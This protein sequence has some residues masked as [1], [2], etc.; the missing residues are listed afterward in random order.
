MY[1]LKE[2][3]FDESSMEIKTH[4]LTNEQHL[5]DNRKAMARKNIDAA[6]KAVNTNEGNLAGFDA[7][8]ELVDS[9]IKNGDVVQ[10][11]YRKIE[12]YQPEKLQPDEH[13]CVTV[14]IPAGVDVSGKADKVSYAT[15]GNFAG[16]DSTGNLTNSGKKATDF[17]TAAQGE[18][19]DTAYQKPSAGIPKSDLSSDVQTSLGLA[20]T[21]LQEHQDISGKANKSEM[22]ITD[23]DGDATKKNIQLKEGLNQD[24]V[25]AHQDVSDKA[26]KSEMAITDVT[27]ESTKKNIQ[28]KDGLDQ[29]VVVEH[30]D[31]SGKAEKSEMAI[32]DV[33][34]DSTKKNIQLKDGLAQ[35]VVVAHQDVSS[36]AEKSEMSITAVTGDDTKKNIQLK[37]GL[38]QNVVIEHQDISGKAEKSEM[39]IT[40]V[41]SDTTKK[42]IQLKDGL[43]QDV[44]VA[45]QDISGKAEKSEMSI[46]D[47]SGDTTKKNIQLKDGLSQAVVVA[48]QDISGKEDTSNKVTSWSQPTTDVNYPS[49]KLVKDSLDGKVDK[50]AGK[51]LVIEPDPHTP[52]TILGYRGDG[53][54]NPD[55]DWRVIAKSTFGESP[56]VLDEQTGEPIVDENA[57]DLWATYDGTGFGAE[58]AVA[59]R[60]GQVIDETYATKTDVAN[61]ADKVSGAVSGHFAS[62]TV[63]GN[64]DDSGYNATNFVQS[65]VDSQTNGNIVVDGTE[66]N[67]Y[68]HPEPD[69]HYPQYSKKL[70]KVSVD[71]TGH[72][73]TDA[74]SSL[75]PTEA[76]DEDIANTGIFDSTYAYNTATNKGATVAHVTNAVSTAINA[77]DNTASSDAGNN[78]QVTVTQE[79][80]VVTAVS[81]RDNS[82]N[83]NDVVGKADKVSGATAGNFAGLNA[84]GNLTDSGSKASDFATAAQGNKADTAIQGVQKN[85]ADLT[86]DANKKVNVV[87]NNATLTV[88]V[89]SSSPVE[90]SADASQNKSVT[91][92]LASFDKTTEPKQYGEG[93]MTGQ[94]KEKLNDIETG[95][96]ANV[97]EKVQ[98]N[99]TDL[100]IT[101]KTVN[102][103]VNDGKLKT[104][105]GSATSATDLFSADASTEATLEIP[106]ASVD[107]TG[108]T[109][110]YSEGLMSASDKEK[111]EGIEA[112]AEEN[113]VETISIGGGTPIAPTTNT[114]NIDIPLADFDD[115]GA[116]TTYTD[117]AMSGEDKEKLN[118]LKNF[119]KVTISDGAATPTTVDCEPSSATD[120][121]TIVAGNNIT[122]TKAQNANTVTIDAEGGTT[123]S[124]GRGVS[125]IETPTATGT[126]YEVSVDGAV[127][128]YGSMTTINNIT[129]SPTD[130]LD[131]SATPN[132]NSGNDRFIVALNQTDN[133]VYLYALKTVKDA[134]DPTNDVAG[135]DVFTL[136]FNVQVHR[137]QAHGF[138]GMAGVQ[139]VRDSSA[140]IVL[141]SSTESYPSNVGECSVN[142]STTVWNNAGT[143]TTIT[144]PVTHESKDYYGYRLIY[145]GDTSLGVSDTIQVDA[146]FSVVENMSGTAEYTG[147][148]TQYTGGSA[149]EI[150]ANTHEV[151]V[152]PGDG[153]VIDTSTNTLTVNVKADGGIK[154]YSDGL[155]VS[156]GLDEVTE[157]VVDTVQEISSDMASKLTTNF[158]YPMIT[159]V[160]YDFG[161]LN[162]GGSCICQLFSVPFRHPIVVDETY[163]MIYIKDRGYSQ[164]NVMFGI[165]QYDPAGNNNTGKTDF[166]CD[167]G[168]V[169]IAKPTSEKD[170]LEFPIKHVN[171]DANFRALRPDCMYYAVLAMPPNAGSG[172]FLASA[173]NY[174]DTVNSMPTLNWRITNCSL[175]NWNDPTNATLDETQVH[176]WESGYNEHESMN[177]FFMQIRNHVPQNNNNNGN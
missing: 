16:L 146:R 80:G 85:G 30:Q 24:V 138:Y 57:T 6:K 78:V 28:L 119:S 161:S 128:Y 1:K 168:A 110:V 4:V 88:T 105:I 55:P 160:S 49:E 149:I 17:A 58:R 118:K 51:G 63:S 36:K 41:S 8:G 151:S 40:D 72:V 42:T 27:G 154:L 114:T 31:I 65:V 33:S 169:S 82:I 46:T 69:P 19:A 13:G 171:S 48:H 67:V 25:V 162:I 150:D 60:I 91:I 45:H 52:S 26:V 113:D 132:V 109:P 175:I 116:Q 38:S 62:L 157:E 159:D 172:I 140:A 143:T 47:V 66:I 3:P 117:G 44:V 170:I 108:V 34:G 56:E 11:V 92:P 2:K 61:K 176:W 59:D 20:D 136:A 141:H 94:E 95:A 173:P 96:Q 76:T 99:G 127:G 152:R 75:R 144:D 21:A 22:I 87:V 81:V 130:L 123:V 84:S 7:N 135:V 35:D 155:G 37:D 126:D 83:A 50:E 165:Y 104:K 71:L 142:G 68:T 121:L 54:S 107:N 64:L 97:I 5:D 163:V 43:A 125:V 153:L 129:T 120:T 32:A 133:H 166:I 148:I 14:V 9:G 131:A 101:S 10:G 124:A 70:Y 53:T 23:V 147:S 174:N 139:L 164:S 18:L 137:T 100:T 106:L 29:D 39:S 79:D 167:T 90:F 145:V 98:K 73:I 177:R 93:L 102:V 111:L 74:N 12:G 77:L 115:T 15:E 103:V 122:L 156:L 134:L 158:P 112:G 89:G 86:P